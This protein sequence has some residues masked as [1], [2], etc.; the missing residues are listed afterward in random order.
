MLKFLL[1]LILLTGFAH[2]QVGEIL[3]LEGGTDSHLLRNGQRMN[4]AESMTLET[5]DKI[6]SADSH[7][8]LMVYPKVQISLV[9]GTELVLNSHLI[10]ESTTEKSSSVVGL[11]KGLI[12]IMVSKDEG[13]IVDQKVDAKDITFS[14]RGTE[15]E[16]SVNDD[17]AD[18]DV[19]EGEVE[20]ASPYVQTFVPEIVKKGEG[21]R[22]ERKAKKFSRRAFKERVRQNKFL[23]KE[24][25]K[26]RWKERKDKR[27]FRKARNVEHRE[28]RNAR[29]EDRKALRK[30]RKNRGR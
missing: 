15:Y 18:L 14:V 23:K 2:A 9:K 30:E 25:L 4:L 22:F 26:Q 1:S 24:A 29:R 21:F 7:V 16:V 12:R 19:I 13:E 27:T 28:E 17:D 11:I 20:V 8:T 5:G 6:F 3:S 10:E